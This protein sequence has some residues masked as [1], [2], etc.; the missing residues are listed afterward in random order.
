MNT[1]KRVNERIAKVA[2]KNHK[3]DLAKI[4]SFMPIIKGNL[5]AT[6]KQVQQFQKAEAIY[7]QANK[8]DYSKSPQGLEKDINAAWDDFS[9]KA[10]DID[11][12]PLATDMYKEYQVALDLIDQINDNVME[13]ERLKKLMK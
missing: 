5:K 1:E 13:I 9:K 7:S 11:I 8:S 12:N 6:Q 4:S 3:V 2:L 10:K